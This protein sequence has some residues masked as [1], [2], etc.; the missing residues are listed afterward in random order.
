MHSDA[1]R[2]T[3]PASLP[4]H[5]PLP[6]LV[7]RSGPLRGSVLALEKDRVSLGRDPRND[8]S[9]ADTIISSFHAAILRDEEGRFWIEDVGSKNGT[10][11]GGEPIERAELREGDVFFLCQSGPEIQFTLDEPRLPG[12]VESSTATFVRTGSFGKA[13]REL[14]PRSRSGLSSILRLTG[15]RKLL[16]YRLEEETRR[17]RLRYLGLVAAFFVL[18][19]LALAGTV[20]VQTRNPRGVLPE[21]IAQTPGDSRD[22]GTVED[23]GANGSARRGASLDLELD[24]I[25]G[26]LFLSYRERPIGLVRVTNA[27]ESPLGGTELRLEFLGAAESLLVEPYTALVPE[28]P[29]GRS[30]EVALTPK[31]SA[32]ALSDRTREVAARAT[33]L[34]EGDILAATTRG[35]FVHGRHVMSWEDPERIAAFVDPQDP[36]VVAFVRSVWSRRP[37]TSRHEFPPANIVGALTLLTGLA[38]LGL[39]YLPDAK[40]PISA[41]IDEKAIDSINY[42]GETLLARAG[43]CDDLS[44]LSCSALEAS[45]IPTALAIG[46]GHVIFLFDTGVPAATLRQSPLDPTTVLVRG[47]RVWMPVESTDYARPG[48]NFAS[49]W[50]AAWRRL[51]AISSG[52]MRFVELKEALRRYQPMN[53]PPDARTGERIATTEWASGRLETSVAFG[54]AS[55]RRLFRENLALRVQEIEKTFEEGP[56]R[57]Q[58]IGVLYARSGLLDEA[59]A[60]FEKAVFGD[61]NP[62]SPEMAADWSAAD[63][64]EKAVLLTD[65]ASCIALGHRSSGDLELSARYTELALSGFPPDARSERGE[66]MLRLALVHRLRGDLSAER[67][68]REQAFALDPGLRTT[69]AGLVEED[70]TVAGEEPRVFDYL[71][72]GLR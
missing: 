38:E 5:G 28:I 36:A 21:P 7:F 72:A 12:I 69:Y 53:P 44:V 17:A 54:L 26:S 52:E 2:A 14:L 67:S 45:G 63:D 51:Q 42:P 11:L 29:P 1:S 70:G 9:I 37:E 40:N 33:L 4:S 60:I 27:R 64:E 41:R 48:A 15:V 8:V 66:L 46:A 55:L 23:G 35:V 24:P 58:A 31:L 6:K 62:P 49:A 59:R 43:D 50:S 39:R 3:S 19:A 61:G 22:R 34:R 25:F 47:E 65:L 18:S 56:A 57:Q 32:E 71:R 16:D 20:Y 13:L 10:F 68:W 30:V